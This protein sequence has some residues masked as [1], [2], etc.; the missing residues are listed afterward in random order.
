MKIYTKVVLNL[1]GEVIEEDSYEYV[2]P[3]AEC[4]GGGGGSSGRMEWPGYMQTQ[5]QTWLTTM[6]G[7]MTT[8]NPYTGVLA[9]DPTAHISAIETQMTNL[10]A[11]Y[12]SVGTTLTTTKASW[13]TLASA[14]QVKLD[15]LFLSAPTTTFTST[16]KTDWE[17][18]V[19][20][21]AAKLDLLLLSAPTTAAIAA[22]KTAW[23]TLVVAVQVKLDALLLSTPTSTFLT[24]A[25]SELSGAVVAALDADTI[26]RFEAGMR[27]INAVQTSSFVLG[28]AALYARVG[29]DLS[30]MT[31]AMRL[32]TIIDRNRG[33]VEGSVR[34]F[35][36]T[37][38]I[39]AA[40]NAEVVKGS[41]Q[42][43]NEVQK[44]VLAR[45][46]AI[47]EGSFRLF[48]QIEKFALSRAALTSAYMDKGKI[49]IVA[50]KERL[51]RQV[52][53]DLSEATWPFYMYQQAGNLLGSI[54]AG[55]GAAAAINKPNPTASAV[56]GVITGAVS[57][58]MI[59]GMAT[60]WTGPGAIIGGVVGAVVG[61]IGGYLSAQ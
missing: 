32:Q 37:Q 34:L 3:V 51:D 45:D 19:A 35:D 50:E 27:D 54:G 14:V 33:V 29:L 8:T 47:S 44:T 36:E 52:D 18:L 46:V 48:D 10:I 13:E 6:N 25:Q 59:G 43:F 42:L 61:G 2:G 5:H 4:K 7:L 12:D 30:K 49:A 38:K 53:L 20:A 23:E 56:G 17:T 60:S 57:G 28:K 11:F 22:A 55:G 21:I 24:T 40:R 26:G 41:F 58:A 15:A 16:A 9:Y 39:I 1:C 31:G